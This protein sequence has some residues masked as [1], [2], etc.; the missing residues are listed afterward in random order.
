VGP[1]TGARAPSLTVDQH[2]RY[3]SNQEEDIDLN[4]GEIADGNASVDGT[5][6][7]LFQLIARYGVR[8]QIKSEKHGWPERIRAVVPGRG[9]VGASVG[10]SATFS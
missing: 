3:G 4:C 9:D 10:P 2:A 8:R 7:K 1:R 6:E 5:G